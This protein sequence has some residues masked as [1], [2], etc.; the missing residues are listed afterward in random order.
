MQVWPEDLSLLDSSLVVV[1]SDWLS[2]SVLYSHG[3]RCA[4]II[5]YVDD[6]ITIIK[7]E[8]KKNEAL[9]PGIS[10]KCTTWP[11]FCLVFMSRKL[12]LAVS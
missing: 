10:L 7:E 6:S 2:R 3:P 8:V 12:W 5:T 4:H 9:V 1:C 11:E